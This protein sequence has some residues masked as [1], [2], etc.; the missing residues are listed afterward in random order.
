MRRS[1]LIPVI[2]L[3]LAAS[4][5]S[6]GHV[7]AHPFEQDVPEDR[8]YGGTVVIGGSEGLGDLNPITT[9]LFLSGQIS[10]ELLFMPILRRNQDLQPE[11]ALA[12]SW[13]IDSDSTALTLHLRG[14]VFWSDGVRV[15]AHDVKF[16]YEL[17]KSPELA[18]TWTRYLPYYGEAEVVDSLTFRVRMRP[19]ADFLEAWVKPALPR[20]LLQD[21]PPAEMRKHHFSVEPV[22]NGPFIIVS[23]TAGEELILAANPSFP[24]DLG[25]RPYVDRIVY[26]FIPESSTR[27]TELLTGRV[28]F[29]EVEPQQLERIE[30]S[31]TSRVISYP[32]ASYSYIAWNTRRPLFQDAR[33]RRALLMAIDRQGIIDGILYGRADLAGSPV[34][35][36]L[37]N[38]DPDAGR[39]LSHDPDQARRMLAQAGWMDRD[40]NGVVEDG[41]GA[42]FRFTL[43]TSRGRD[44]RADVVEKIA[45]DLRK[46]GVVAVPR[47]LERTAA[48]A[49]TQ[50]EAR[51]FDALFSVRHGA[52]HAMPEPGTFHCANRA[53]ILQVSGICDPELD[54][55]MDVLPSVADRDA[56]RVLWHRYQRR[57]AE[58]QPHAFLDHPHGLVAVDAALRAVHPDA[59][60]P[61]V[62]AQ[63]WWIRPEGRTTRAPTHSRE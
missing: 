32:M 34:A 26:R 29:I 50:G 23:R 62:G 56:A 59:R 11:P 2:G 27:L 12:K 54:H 47:L 43:L 36:L 21:V 28:H 9:T 18:S 38:H 40:R 20:H 33:V 13:E 5:C 8:R 31:M 46:V 25:G 7:D 4:A 6:S 37:W 17:G 45:S 53:G 41:S 24:E 63:K 61:F 30:R 49:L 16:T 14:D 44:V 55:L 22:G 42:E 48:N 15:T 10:E 39:D 52:V 51:D 57:L 19:H 58:L 1:R 35:P 60:G 3:L